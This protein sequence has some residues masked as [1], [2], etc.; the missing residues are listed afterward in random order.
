VES[1]AAAKEVERVEV[2]AA[3]KAEAKEV[4]MEGV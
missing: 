4:A 1:T 3:S 2:S